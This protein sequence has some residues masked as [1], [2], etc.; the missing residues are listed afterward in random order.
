MA[1]EDQQM[2]RKKTEALIDE[3]V[4]KQRDL[5]RSDISNHHELNEVE[6][7]NILRGQDRGR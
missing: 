7:E 2:P 4:S 3:I 1:L 5:A 6:Q